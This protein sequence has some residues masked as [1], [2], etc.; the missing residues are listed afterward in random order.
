[1]AASTA[2]SAGEPWKAEDTGPWT[3]VPGLRNWK[4][5][6]VPE[7]A[8]H[9][10]MV[11]YRRAFTLTA[12]QAAGPATLSLGGIDEVDQTWVNGRVIRNTFGWGTPRTY[13]LP[14]G[15]LR[16]GDNVAGR[17][18]AE[19]LGC[20]RDDRAG[21]R[22]RA[23]V[24]GRDEGPAGAAAGATARCRSRWGVRPRAPWETIS[25]LTTLYNGM[26]API[27]P[28]GLRGV[29]VVPGRVERRRTRPGTR[30]CSAA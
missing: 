15:T 19:H 18:R 29:V 28:Y 7:L 12:A 26:I 2:P 8:N 3:D 9:D 1:M 4:T 22:D 10:G 5:W 23:D 17:E 27:G 20:R 21:R 30:S 6:G 24:R 11:W 25:G 14:A 16:A 13:R